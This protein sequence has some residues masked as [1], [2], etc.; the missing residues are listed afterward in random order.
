MAGKISDL[1][2]FF[3]NVSLNKALLTCGIISAVFYIIT[4]LLASQRYDGYS[5]IDQNYSELLATGAPTRG[6][7]VSNTLHPA[8]CNLQPVIHI[9]QPTP[10]LPPKR[11]KLSQEG[12]QSRHPAP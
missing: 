8:T 9:S 12:N 10:S 4:D 1:Y 7:F 11:D 6:E 2:R 3:G 5:I